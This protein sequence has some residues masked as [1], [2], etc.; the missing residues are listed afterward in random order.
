MSQARPIARRAEALRDAARRSLRTRS[1]CARRA[2]PR[3]RDRRA[4]PPSPRP[5]A[6]RPPVISA[7]RPSSRNRS[8]GEARGPLSHRRPSGEQ[9]DLLG[10]QD[11][12]AGRPCPWSGRSPPSI[13]ARRRRRRAPP[14]PRRSE[15][16]G[17]PSRALRGCHSPSSPSMTIGDEPRQDLCRVR[18]GSAPPFGELLLR[19]VRSDG[20]PGRPC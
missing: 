6:P 11:D 5:S 7:R 1:P 18:M 10:D 4:S 2:R 19:P 12:A 16:H 17:H 15:R 20:W 3:S 14:D 13:R 8:R 9:I